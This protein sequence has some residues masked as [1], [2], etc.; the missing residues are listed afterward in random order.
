MHKEKLTQITP[1]RESWKWWYVASQKVVMQ[2]QCL[3]LRE[4]NDLGWN[5]ASKEAIVQFQYREC[6]KSVVAATALS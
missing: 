5:G 1:V 4:E 2:N 3:K 6:G